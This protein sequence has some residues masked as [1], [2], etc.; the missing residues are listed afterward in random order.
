VDALSVVGLAREL[1]RNSALA[2][3]DGRRVE[4]LVAPQFEKLAQP[5]HVDALQ[6]ALASKCG[7]SRGRR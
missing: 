5:R 3:Y 7:W 4:L 6:R 2:A 1:A